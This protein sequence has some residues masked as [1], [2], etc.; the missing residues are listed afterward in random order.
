MNFSIF[1]LWI[2]AAI[3]F[4]HIMVDSSIIRPFREWIKEKIPEINLLVMK[5]SLAEGIE[6]YQCVG[7]H[8]GIFTGILLSLLVANTF[9]NGVLITILA[10][11][12]SSFLSQVGAYLIVYLEANSVIN[13]KD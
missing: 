7:W 8:M 3:G 5:V 12:A 1:I 9:W 2:F 10:G 11:G 4:T 13:I 6:C